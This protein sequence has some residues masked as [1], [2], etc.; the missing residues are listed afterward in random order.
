[1]RVFMFDIQTTGFTRDSNIVQLSAFNDN[2]ELNVCQMMTKSA[3]QETLLHQ[4]ILPSHL[5]KKPLSVT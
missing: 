5:K 3:N 2:A 4:P 1:M